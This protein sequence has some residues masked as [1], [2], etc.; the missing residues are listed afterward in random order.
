MALFPWRWE[1][2]MCAS[3]AVS[4]LSEDNGQWSIVY[5]LVGINADDDFLAA[6]LPW[7]N[8]IQ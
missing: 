6:N 7:A 4:M 1:F 8:E 5:M 2:G 3:S